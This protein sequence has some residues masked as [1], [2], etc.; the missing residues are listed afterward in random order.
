MKRCIQFVVVAMAVLL[1]AQP[2]TAGIPC[3]MGASGSGHCAFC[4]NKAMSRM[5][6]SCQM[7]QHLSGS[8]CTQNCSHSTLPQV[9]AQ[10]EAA[11]KSKTGRAEYVAAAS[12]MTAD[13]DMVF[14][15][16]PPGAF[17]FTPHARYI[18]FQVFRI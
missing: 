6:K 4:C 13:A 1:A 14:V 16:A 10:S 17:V 8:G 3:E 11:V 15:V 2:A 9:A 5:G 12:R 7:P 18:F